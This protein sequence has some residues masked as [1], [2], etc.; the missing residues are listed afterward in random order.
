MTDLT[1]FVPTRGRTAQAEILQSDFLRTCR[2]N[3]EVIFIVSSDDSYLPVYR[4][5]R[6]SGQLHKIIEV[7]PQR[8][9][10]TDPLNFG[11]QKWL[12]DPRVFPSFAVGFMGDDHR[13]RTAGW[14]VRYVEA[15]TALSGRCRDRSRPG[16]GL[17]YGND[18]LQGENLPTQVAMTTN[19]PTV[20]NRMVPW[21]LAHLYTDTYWLELGK[22]L[23]KISYLDDVVIEHMH[24]GAGKA[25]VDA[26]YEFSGNSALDS[27]DRQS[28]YEVVTDVIIPND[29]ERLRRLM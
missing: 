19:I 7:T 21:E 10:L 8:R 9:G 15:L 3:T 28:F 20:L 4:M 6:D 17:V 2:G 13:P 24:P 11:F 27:S 12:A 18:L 25:A 29:V 1:M 16:L 22:K 5:M 26:G 14:D 23:G